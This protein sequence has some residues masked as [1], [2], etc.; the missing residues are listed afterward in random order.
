MFS[1]PPRVTPQKAR[2]A[3]PSA[4]VRLASR[5]FMM[6]GRAPMTITHWA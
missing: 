4:R 2:P 5:V 1:S 3:L 6:V